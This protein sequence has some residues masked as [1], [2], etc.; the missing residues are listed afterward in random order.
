MEY[1]AID[2]HVRRSE[3]RIEDAAGRVV[4]A[5]R[6]AT[7][8]TDLE[9][10]LRDRGRLRILIES[11]TD[12]EWVAQVVEALGHEVIVADP[13]FL[14]MYGQRNRRIKTDRRDVAALVAACRLG[15]YRPASRVSAAQRARRQELRVRRQL[16]QMRTR[17]IS[18]VRS[19]VRQEGVRVGTGASATLVARLDRVAVSPAL[20]RGLAPMRELLLHLQTILEGLDA[21]LAEVAAAD[22]TAQ[23]LMTVP[24]VGPITALT[25]VAVVD[26]PTRFGGDARRV[27]AF[28]GLVPSE[29]S[30]AERRHRGRIT[31]TGPPEVRSLLVQVSWA[32]WRSRTPAAAALRA[33]AQTLAARRGRRIAIVA[34]ARRV[35]RILF[36]LWRDG[37]TFR[38]RVD[39]VA[40]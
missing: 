31:K 37:T 30:S 33:W 5:R 28:L 24:G 1:G 15:I 25:Y 29:D 35:S 4:L 13:N 21:R 40:A 2:L 16:V 6:I 14:P 7:T 9:R 10:T 39:T 8:R 11:S 23:R 26:T 36:A 38:R 32:I 17:A 19:L 18:V 34:L 22:A 3:I 12:S 20:A 27:S